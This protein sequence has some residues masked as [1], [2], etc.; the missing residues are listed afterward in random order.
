MITLNEYLN[1]YENEYQRMKNDPHFASEPK[2]L[3]ERTEDDPI[4]WEFNPKNWNG[5]DILR[6]W[7]YKNWQEITIKGEYE[8]KFYW[9]SDQS[10]VYI[11]GKCE[12]FE[13]SWYKHRGNTETIKRNGQLISLDEYIE[14]C[15]KLGVELE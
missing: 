14:I 9:E 12:W 1:W 8:I 7:L 3:F 5:G 2:F 13:V 6:H 11:L 15:N 10:T 4:W